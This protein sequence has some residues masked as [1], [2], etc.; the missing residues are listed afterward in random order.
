M[1]VKIWLRSLPTFTRA[2]SLITGSKNSV[3]TLK[4]WQVFKWFK[5]DEKMIET[6]EFW[7]IS[8]QAGLD[9]S[10]S[11]EKNEIFIHIYH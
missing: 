6:H 7:D 2:A 9:V 8:H 3:A 5:A 11:A 4:A 10:R 1:C